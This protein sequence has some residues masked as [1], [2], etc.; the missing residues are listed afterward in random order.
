MPATFRSALVLSALL[1][2]ATL[3]TARGTVAQAPPDTAALS[4]RATELSRASQ[5]REAA[6]VLEQLTKIAPAEGRHWLR[7]GMALQNAGEH[8]RA[9][10]ALRRAF[11]F[12]QQPGLAYRIAVG[13]ATQGLKD[14]AA[15]FLDSAMALGFGNADV[16]SAEA[17]FRAFHDDARFRDMPARLRGVS[18]PCEAQPGF[19]Q[20][21][22][23]VGTW[24]Q[25][26]K[27]GQVVGVTRVEADV[28]GCALVERT[29]NPPLYSAVAFHYYSRERGTWVQHYLDSTA[30]ELWFTGSFR[31]DTL[32]Y[33]LT[34]APTN[35]RTLMRN[36]MVRESTEKIRW[37]F[38]QS[39]DNGR[40]WRTAFDGYY[41]R[42]RT[43]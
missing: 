31:G 33:L 28:S 5:W 37:L 9:T 3:F 22:H 11:T 19:H 25:Q 18:R 42:K 39:N 16:Y 23:W 15:A 14:S 8:A 32:V 12:Q 6:A 27:N 13:F 35:G 41:V 1:A 29:T 20:L 40:S 34:D 26:A 30:K 4:L 7:L 24:E 17:A 2:V 21:D 38:E 10:S 36:T 43:T